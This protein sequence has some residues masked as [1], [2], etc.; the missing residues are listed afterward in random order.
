M[1]SPKFTVASSL[2][3]RVETAHTDKAMPPL[4]EKPTNVATDGARVRSKRLPLATADL[5]ENFRI[6]LCFGARN[7]LSVPLLS[8]RAGVSL[9]IVYA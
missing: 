3:R 5:L 4:G 7:P 2:P 1:N 9:D 6:L 8:L